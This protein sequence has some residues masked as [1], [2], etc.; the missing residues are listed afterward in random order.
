MSAAPALRLCLLRQAKAAQARER[1]QRRRY[2]LVLH[3]RVRR[4]P[5][6]ARRRW[7][8]MPVYC[9]V[10]PAGTLCTWLSASTPEQAWANLLV[11]A[12]HMP[13]CGNEGFKQRGYTVEM[14][15][16]WR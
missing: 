9:P 10:T 13:Y 1:R 4:E 16:D 14:Y 15:I 2:G 3:Q 5:M 12:A 11:D 7:H 8:K 6:Q